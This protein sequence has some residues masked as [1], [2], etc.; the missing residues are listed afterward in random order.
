MELI[1]GEW[2]MGT[3]SI[4]R[5]RTSMP[6]PMPDT[7]M[8]INT[9][10]RHKN[11]KR[12]IPTTAIISAPVSKRR[13]GNAKHWVLR[14]TRGGQCTGPTLAGSPLLSRPPPPKVAPVP[15][16]AT[17]P[18]SLVSTYLA[19]CSLPLLS[20]L[21]SLPTTTALSRTPLAPTLAVHPTLHTPSNHR[22]HIHWLSHES[23]QSQQL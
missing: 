12:A 4:H 1:L 14:T 3:T 10:I 2:L 15:V 17:A 9:M 19:R 21:P 16:A 18:P 13:R 7:I 20:P 6:M 5:G 23:R 11:N 8:T 22:S